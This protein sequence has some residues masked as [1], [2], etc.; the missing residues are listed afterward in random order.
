MPY[1]TNDGV[2][3]HY[4]LAGNPNGPPLVLLHGFA[5]SLIDWVELGYSEALGAGYRLI[6]IDARGHGLS[7]KPH[8]PDA[9]RAACWAGDVVA[10]LD[11]LGIPQAHF[12]GYSMGGRIGFMLA[13]YAPECCRSLILGGDGPLEIAPTG[14][15]PLTELMRQGPDALVAVLD[16]VW[17]E[18]MTPSLRQRLLH[19]DTE[20]LIASRSVSEPRDYVAAL[21]NV[22]IPCLIYCGEADG[23]H[24]GA[25][26]AAAKM[27]HA[28]FVSIPGCDHLQ[29]IWRT[30][31]VLPH[32]KAFL[33]DVG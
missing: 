17:G 24:E 6:L 7:D 19:S 2:R 25:Q 16:S 22:T 5:F 28:R 20:A 23:E 1:A 26:R 12:L 4:H 27:P 13:A 3:I 15:D 9:Y 10:V 8:D 32:I 31:L 14:P 29:A 33:S 11:D 30:D 21:P 18:R